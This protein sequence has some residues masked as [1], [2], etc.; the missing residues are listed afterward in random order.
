MRAVYADK[1]GTIERNG[2]DIAYEVYE[3]VGKPTVLLA[4]TWHILDSRHW[5]FQIP[6]LARYFRV[7]T[8]DPVGNGQSSR[9][10]DPNRYGI[11]EELADTLAV[12]DAT[13]TV[14]CVI[15]GLS[16]GG[17]LAVLSA[18]LDP[19]RFD[20][21]IAIAPAHPWCVL[22]PPMEATIGH[23]FDPA[24]ENATGWDTY[25]VDYW[26]KDWEGFSRFFAGEVA[27]DPYSTKGW[28]DQLRWSLQT[29]GEVVAA[30]DEAGPSARGPEIEP[31]V[32]SMELPV[33]IIHGTSDQV[34]DYQSASI[35]LDMLQNGEL[36]TIDGAGHAPQARYPVRVNNAIKVFVD[37]IHPPEPLPA[38]WH[39]GHGRQK[40][41]LFISSP[42]GLGH[43]RRDV[44]IAQEI[45]NL[46]PEIT[47]DW[48][49]Q[50]PVT[51]VLDAAGE[52]IHRASALLA[53]ESAHIEAESGEHNL[54]AFQAL[55]NM[56]EI[57]VA[58]FMVA[59][60]L[61][62]DEHYDLVIGDEAW[63][64]DFH[65][66]E[67]PNLK[68]TAFAWMTDFVGYLPMPERGEREAFVAADYNAQMIDQVDRY[69]RVRDVS[70]F[71]GSPADI[72]S[73]TFG[74]DLPEIRAWTE[75]NFDF[76]GYVTGFDPN[77]LGD[78]AALREELG[79]Q[80]D[81]R[82]CIVSVGGS[83][84]G[85]DMLRKVVQAYPAASRAVSDLRMIVV[86][87]PRI[88]PSTLPTIPGVE[89]RTYVDKLYRHLAVSDL[90]VVQ[91]GLTT[92]ME[93]T[94][95][96]VPFIYVPLREH[97]EQNFH[98]RTRL[99]RYRAGRH[100]DYDDINPDRLAEVVSEEIGRTVDYM[101]VETDGAARAAALITTAL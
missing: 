34:I 35:L 88:D 83:G 15:A 81:E 43:A 8:Y 23:L 80:A 85:V 86:T 6:F 49:A 92:T 100:M 89:Y 93:L 57:Q 68:K 25:N 48:L 77:G 55:R 54:A 71:V 70:V 73:G 90:A 40:K 95:A 72:V 75:D 24:K 4:P 29:N 26:R 98:V 82:V 47:I 97:F 39:A 69:D 45:R 14:R 62:R 5:K 1:T 37:R 84:V 36:L 61:I 33:L 28:D 38:T 11:D 101:D 52:T 99:D 21:V 19:N 12:L 67:N 22:S 66:H 31:A 13:E 3:N 87:G 17:G 7:V 58:N 91:G 16:R 96:K 44:A 53:N 74:P 10:T 51:R 2:A 76:A 42:I 50:D 9:S 79:Y 64:V 18:A 78:R 32:K 27:S 63:E 41:V 56:D 30:A 65:L 46:N 20:G 59:D 60:E 94:A